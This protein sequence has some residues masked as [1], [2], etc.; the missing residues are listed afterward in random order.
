MAVEEKEKK[1][2]ST[3][4]SKE[5]SLTREKQRITISEPG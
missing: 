4:A 2:F 3:T 1:T 5:A